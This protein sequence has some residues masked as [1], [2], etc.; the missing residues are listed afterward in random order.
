MKL[1]KAQQEAWETL[2]EGKYI[3]S[4]NG[5]YSAGINRTVL[6]NLRKKGMIKCKTIFL[7]G[8]VSGDVEVL[9]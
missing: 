6:E 2:K 7:S 9:T 3:P 8:F 5:G 1:T 4:Q